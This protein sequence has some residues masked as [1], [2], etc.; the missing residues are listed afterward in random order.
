[1]AKAQVA[2]DG[3]RRGC[4]GGSAA[5]VGAGGLMRGRN[6]QAFPV[7]ASGQHIAGAR[8]EGHTRTARYRVADSV[9]ADQD[10]VVLLDTVNAVLDD[11]FVEIAGEHDRNR[12]RRRLTSRL[13]V[14]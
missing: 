11:D 9:V 2:V 6:E 14:W 8:G 10:R 1:M 4:C 13:D 7:R 12:R 3:H 5:Q